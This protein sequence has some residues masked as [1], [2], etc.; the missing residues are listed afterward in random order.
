MQGA[1]ALVLVSEKETRRE[2][3]RALQSGGL[4]VQC[5]ESIAM[6]RSDHAGTDFDICVISRRL[7]DGDGLD[8]I[9]EL[10]S[11]DAGIGLVVV[12]N[13]DDEVDAVLALEMGADDFLGAPSRTRELR[14]RVNAVLRRMAFSAGGRNAVGDAG[15]P[16]QVHGLTIDTLARRVLRDDGR[17]AGLTSLEF[18]VLT[19]LVANAGKVISRPRIMQSVHGRDW[20]FNP[21]AVDGI[22][23][24]LRGKLFG[25][26]EGA[27]RIRTVHGRGYMLLGDIDDS[28]TP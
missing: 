6:F 13:R 25:G 3:A 20:S 12:G 4:S 17:E 11:A 8:M 5:S 7:G 27:R 9:R 18:D 14:A 15:Q 26:D 10:R 24:R 2:I 22:V 21:R 23:S 28:G 1:S 19:V 16:L